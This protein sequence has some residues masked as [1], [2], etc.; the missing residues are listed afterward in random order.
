MTDT[1]TKQLVDAQ[2]A[3]IKETAKNIDDVY[4]T[5]GR[6]A[7][8]ETDMMRGNNKNIFLLFCFYYALCLI[9][10]FVLY[11]STDYSIKVIGAR[12]GNRSVDNFI[13]FNVNQ[14]FS[15]YT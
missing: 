15:Y 1:L 8:Y 4:S 10:G 3:A 7:M 6:K 2:N 12:N 11:K 9:V 14:S 5:D 13:G